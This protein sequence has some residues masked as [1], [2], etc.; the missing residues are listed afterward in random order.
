MV[1]TSQ[2]QKVINQAGFIKIQMENFVA[3]LEGV[4]LFEE[5]ERLEQIIEEYSKLVKDINKI[6][7]VV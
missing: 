5:A 7:E 3:K 6:T 2:K 4:D 1:S